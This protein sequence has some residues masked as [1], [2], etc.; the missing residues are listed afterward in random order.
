MALNI[1]NYQNLFLKGINSSTTERAG[2]IQPQK[3]TP[4][5]FMKNTFAFSDAN[6]NKPENRSAFPLDLLNGAPVKGK[7][8][9]LLG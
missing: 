3:Q 9:Y 2:A 1:S 8:L 4:P 5:A 7:E 6:P